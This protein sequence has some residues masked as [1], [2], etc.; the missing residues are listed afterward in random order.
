MYTR[1]DVRGVLLRACCCRRRVCCCEQT[2]PSPR[3]W[4]LSPSAHACGRPAPRRAPAGSGSSTGS[5]ARSVLVSSPSLPVL[6][7]DGEEEAEGSYLEGGYG[8]AGVGLFSQV[9]SDRMRGDDLRLHQERFR[10]DI[11]KNVFTEREQSGVGPGCPG[12]WWSPHPWRGAKTVWMWH[13]RTWFSRHG[14]VG[15][16]IGL[17]DLRGFF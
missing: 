14:G 16:T 13:F 10:L 11:G 8:E 9:T 2:R 5:A 1:E 17:D 12:Q 4:G 3:R 15:E 7:G 6:R